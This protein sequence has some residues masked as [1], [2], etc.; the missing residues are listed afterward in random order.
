MLGVD[1]VRKGQEMTN[2]SRSQV[3]C[4]A[5]VM[6]FVA[7]W[8]LACDGLN[9]PAWAASRSGR[10]AAIHLSNGEVFLGKVLLTPGRRFK[11][12]V[13][14]GGTLKTTDMVTGEDVQYGK[15]RTFTFDAI[16][17]MQFHVE[18][19]EMARA[20]RFVE[21]TDYNEETAEA[22]YTPAEKEYRGKP[23]PLCYLAATVR[24]ES[25]ESLRGHLYTTTVYLRTDR[26]IRRWVLRSKH[27]GKEG[28][29]PDDL[30]Y[31]QRIRMVDE[32]RSMAT[33]VPV[34][35]SALELGPG[36]A[37]Q[38]VTRESLTPVPTRIT[39]KH[40]CVVSSA[41]GE[42]LYLAV[43]R[44]DGCVVGWPGSRDEALFTLA[45][46][47]VERIRDFYNERELLGAILSEDGDELLT[48]V[49]LRR[50]VAP[51]HFGS[52]G[53]EWDKERGTLVEPWRLS[54]WR[55]KYNRENQELALS[56]RGTFFRVVFLPEDPTPTVELSESL[57]NVTDERDAAREDVDDA[58]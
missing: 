43:R 40:S 31:V 26:G 42:D 9:A 35:I 53:G 57:W 23:Y 6:L 12:N 4:C 34:P 56:A 32:G 39:G 14:E 13:P 15:V 45:R 46:D 24:F 38:A 17:D 10:P 2:G 47:H 19:Q 25:G 20:W 55:W 18:R 16:R 36:D 41:F 5:M 37:V 58:Q 27:R 28:Q 49:N 54:L 11:L 52:I 30:V 22:D 1:D 8:W 44:K 48:L 51:T 7:V 21:T 33:E 29:S 3:R 50:R